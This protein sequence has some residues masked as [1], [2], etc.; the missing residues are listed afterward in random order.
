MAR[1]Q[2]RCTYYQCEKRLIDEQT[3]LYSYNPIFVIPVPESLP[4]LTDSSRSSTPLSFTPG[5]RTGTGSANVQLPSKTATPREPIRKF[6]QVSLISMISLTGR[7]PPFGLENASG[8]TLDEIRKAA[9]KPIV[10][11]P[12]CTTSNGRGLLRF[13]DVF[14]QSA[15]VKGYQIYVMCVR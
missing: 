3:Y 7:V 10:V 5:R 2:V 15:P 11:F 8:Q 6:R 1:H 14:H 4:D 9:S 12:E 13:A